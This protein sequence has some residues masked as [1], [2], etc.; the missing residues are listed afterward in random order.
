MPAIRYYTKSLLYPIASI[1]IDCLMLLIFI[2]AGANLIASH[3]VAANNS[4]NQRGASSTE[5]LLPEIMRDDNIMMKRQGRI[6]GMR[7]RTL[8]GPQSIYHSAFIDAEDEAGSRHTIGVSIPLSKSWE[9][10]LFEN[11][12]YFAL[13][14]DNHHAAR[15]STDIRLGLNPGHSFRPWLTLSPYFNF[16]D[17]KGEGLGVAL[18]FTNIWRNGAVLSAEAYAWRPWDEGYSTIIENGQ[19]HGVGADFTLPI[20]KNLQIIARAFYEELEL[21]E[22]AKSGAQYAGHRYLINVRGYC[23]LLHSDEAYMDYGFRSDD[24][25]NEFLAGTELGIFMQADFQ[26][27]FKPGGFHAVNPVPEVFAQELGISFQKA[28][29]PRLGITGEGFIGRDPDRD[30]KFGELYGL[31]GRFLA[32]LSPHVRVWAE[33]AYL[34]TNTTL[35][36]AGGRETTI[37]FGLNYAF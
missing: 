14:K 4:A 27:Y 30:L 35:E 24:L 29:S 32:V 6:E 2:I 37:S 25:K 20:L 31:R 19:K 7:M 13:K 17:A 10:G 16:D 28:I 9:I 36:S 11:I 34:K 23:R 18:G 26:R 3:A 15:E 33:A 5:D 8:Y 1:R 12:S 22:G 21:G